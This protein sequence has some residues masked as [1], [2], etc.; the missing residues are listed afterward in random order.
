M[1]ARAH[2]PSPLNASVC[3][4]AR[5]MYDIYVTVFM[6]YVKNTP[7]CDIICTHSYM[8][9]CVC[10]CVCVYVLVCVCVCWCACEMGRQSG[11][12]SRGWCKIGKP[13]IGGGVESERASDDTERLLRAS[14]RSQGVSAHSESLVPGSYQHTYVCT[15]KTEVSRHACASNLSTFHLDMGSAIVSISTVK[16]LNT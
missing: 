10:V 2:T 16:R 13:V 11:G 12:V 9:V 6:Y 5:C 1:Q 4:R 8:C 15:H 14:L 7:E 3:W